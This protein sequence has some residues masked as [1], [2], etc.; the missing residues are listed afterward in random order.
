MEDS[1]DEWLHELLLHA[2]EENNASVAAT[3]HPDTTRPVMRRS[4]AAAWPALAT[5][6]GLLMSA[7]VGANACVLGSLLRRPRVVDHTC[8]YVANLALAN[9]V[10]CGIVLPASLA[11]LVL[12]NWVF[13]RALC[14]CL[15]MIQVSHK[16]KNIQGLHNFRFI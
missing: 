9:L 12:Q 4:L 2:L 7:G 11:V 1:S 6:Y 5:L 13:G 16:P 15:P 3:A 10:Q 14:Y 8:I